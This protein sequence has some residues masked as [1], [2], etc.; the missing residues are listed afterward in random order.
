MVVWVEYPSE[1]VI[2]NTFP[3]NRQWGVANDPEFDIAQLTSQTLPLT[4]RKSTSSFRK[5]LQLPLVVNVDGKVVMT[6]D[7]GTLAA[8]CQFS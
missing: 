4:S 2:L 6:K 1:Q 3:L 8:N 5:L 7:A